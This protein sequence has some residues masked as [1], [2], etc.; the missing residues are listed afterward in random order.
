MIDESL[1]RPAGVVSGLIAAAGTAG[2]VVLIGRVSLLALFVLI[3]FLYLDRVAAVR[4]MRWIGGIDR[5]EIA[6]LG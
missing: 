2:I 1:P 4:G 5:R 6:G 3:V